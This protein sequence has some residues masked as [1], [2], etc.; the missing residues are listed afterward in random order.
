MVMV[1]Q[2][3]IQETPENKE[4]QELL[5]ASPMSAAS[6]G[7]RFIPVVIFQFRF[8]TKR[9]YILETQDFLVHQE[10]QEILAGPVM[11][12]LAEILEIQEHLEILAQEQTQDQVEILEP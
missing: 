4:I 6:S 10:I 1:E 9:N 3:G 7:G 8:L 12:G 2:Q 11:L 5:G